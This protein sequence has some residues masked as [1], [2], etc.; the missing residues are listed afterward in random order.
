[1]RKFGILTNWREKEKKEKK[2]KETFLLVKE[3]GR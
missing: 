3:I 2:R 1:V